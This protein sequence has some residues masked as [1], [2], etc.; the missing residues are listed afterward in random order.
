MRVLVTG[1]RDFN[2]HEF[3]WRALDALQRKR[4]VDVLIHGTARG[5]D[6]WSAL[7][8]RDRGVP[9][10]KYPA[11]WDA[12]GKAAGHIRNKQML[13]EGKPDLLVA[14]PGGRGTA[15]MKRQATGVGM[16]IWAPKYGAT[17]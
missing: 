12:Y 4:G 15:D 9:E 1:G 6:S 2:D 8:A 3:I 14:F 7:W 17:T 5:A 13:V 10:E 16:L 11:N